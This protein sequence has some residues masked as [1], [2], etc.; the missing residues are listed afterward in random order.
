MRLKAGRRRAAVVHYIYMR[1]DVC[2]RHIN[3]KY[4]ICTPQQQQ[5]PSSQNYT[6]TFR[7]F[8]IGIKLVKIKSISFI[9]LAPPGTLELFVFTQLKFHTPTQ[10]RP[11]HPQQQYDRLYRGGGGGTAKQMLEFIYIFYFQQHQDLYANKYFCTNFCCQHILLYVY[12]CCL[13]T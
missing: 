12:V 8:Y 5:H 13:H 9:S 2:L 6:H 11:T 4:L 7:Y 1:R 3:T 10:T